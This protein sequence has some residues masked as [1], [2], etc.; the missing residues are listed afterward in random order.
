MNPTAGQYTRL[1]QKDMFAVFVPQARK[2]AYFADKW[3][4]ISS[5]IMCYQS[6]LLPLVSD[7]QILYIVENIS[8]RASDDTG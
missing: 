3:P 2:T 7:T 5:T 8:T 4:S 6:G 1:Y